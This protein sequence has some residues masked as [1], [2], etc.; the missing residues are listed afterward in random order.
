VPLS[1]GDLAVLLEHA[2]QSETGHRMRALRRAATA[3]RLWREE[4]IDLVAAD[5]ALTELPAVGPWVAARIEAWFDAPP[6]IPQPDETRSGFLT[7]AQARAVLADH[8]DW[9]S[10]PHGDLQVHS[11]DSDGSQPLETM[12]DLAHRLGRAYIAIT[13]H[14]ETL[15]I[16]N[17]MDPERRRA[18]LRR[19]DACN[20]R[21]AGSGS[22]F[23]VL[24]SIEMDVFVDGTVDATPEMLAPL[25]LVLGA[26][27]SKLRVTGDST[28]RYLAAIRHPSVHVLAHPQARMFGR[29]VGLHAEWPR[30]FDEAAARGKALELDATPWRQDLSVELTRIAVASGVRWFTIGSDAHSPRELE[31]LPF[32][33]AT[34]ALAG[35][36]RDRVL[37]YRAADEVVEW[38][39]GV[40]AGGV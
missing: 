39:A 20:T 3:A 26:F 22:A 34:A 30:V 12:A 23:R 25:D 2:A 15:R 4:A 40:E 14:S 28:D 24:R 38:A 8:P 6:S 7:Y 35:V 18:Q 16:A 27:H 31:F 11:T 13:D 17:G 5:R 33:M 1:N 21:F 37:N 9:E 36:R 32:G 19:I 29:R 10:A